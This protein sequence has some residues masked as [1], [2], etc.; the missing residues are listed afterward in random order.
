MRVAQPVIG[1]Q[2][3]VMRRMFANGGGSVNQSRPVWFTIAQSMCNFI[4]P[5]VCVLCG[6]AGQTAEGCWGLDLCRYCEAACERAGRGASMPGSSTHTPFASTLALY[7]YADPVD[8]L[9]TSLKFGREPAFARVLGTLLARRV[10]AAAPLPFPEA[11]V[12]VP[13]HRDRL[14]E[15]GFNQS[16]RI[17]HHTAKR[18]GLPVV[19]QLLRRARRTKAQSGLSAAERATNLDHAFESVRRSRMPRHVALLDD[20]MTTGNTAQAATLALLSAGVERVDVWVCARTP[21]N[22]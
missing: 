10:R 4:A 15:R 1:A 3:L 17:A 20:V 21:R 9:I 18:L 22:P 8:T 19:P 16:V 12:P 7:I 14:I 6:G 2:T 5:P 13:L 11:I